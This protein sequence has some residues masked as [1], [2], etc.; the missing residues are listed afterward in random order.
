MCFGWGMWQWLKSIFRFAPV[1]QQPFGMA[2]IL[3]A[4]IGV[5]PQHGASWS[6]GPCGL[7]AS[8]IN[9]RLACCHVPRSLGLRMRRVCWSD[10]WC[11][12]SQGKQLRHMQHL[13]HRGGQGS[14]WLMHV[15]RSWETGKNDLSI[16]SEWH[17]ATD[18]VRVLLVT[19]HP[20][21]LRLVKSCMP[22][23]SWFL[24]LKRWSLWICWALCSD[25]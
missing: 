18:K 11:S 3:G 13:Q 15:T 17:E 8:C 25:P 2:Y 9:R 6:L 4:I 12:V 10:V 23:L 19:W 5:C 24:D 14:V 21:R 16:L 22:S 1:W 7:T 20:A